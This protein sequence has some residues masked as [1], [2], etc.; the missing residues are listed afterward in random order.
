[1]I[2]QDTP[3]FISLREIGRRLNIP[4][5]T[6]VY[7]KDRFARFIPVAG[8]AGRR[9]RYPAEV[10]EIF[11]RIREMF[12]NNWS[13]EQI[14]RELALRFNGVFEGG[15]APGGEPAAGA[16][17][18]RQ[19]ASALEKMSDLLEN[20]SLFRSE[21]RSLRDEVAQLRRERAEAETAWQE[22]V[23]DLERQLED[24]RRGAG[25]GGSA[26]EFPPSEHLER[27]LVIRSSQGEYLGV[28]SRDNRPFSLQDFIGLMERRMARGQSVALTWRRQGLQ[29]E[30][31][32]SAPAEDGRERRILLVTARTVTPSNNVVTQIVRL[33]VDGQ[34][35]PDSLLVGLFK[36]IKESFGG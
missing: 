16:E 6:V 25:E 36:Q 30:L 8:S 20:Q 34:T 35:A 21:I 27:P 13:A 1:M 15:P 22:R 10:L 31:S 33:S 14:E 28:M 9:Q 5:S 18:V 12:E 2:P 17:T 23:R 24:L 3:T 7:Y 19:F 26:L 32:V 4:P 11:R 29:W